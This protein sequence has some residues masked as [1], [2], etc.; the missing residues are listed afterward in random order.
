MSSIVLR[1]VT[2]S[3]AGKTA[4]H[5]L[6]LEIEDGEFVIIVGPYTPSEVVSIAPA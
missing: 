2:K 1:H 5:D 6:D 4:V 3:F